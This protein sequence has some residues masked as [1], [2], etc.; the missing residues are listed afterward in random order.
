M[1]TTKSGRTVNLTEKAMNSVINSTAKGSRSNGGNVQTK[2]RGVKRN[3]SES[4]DNI[5]QS[6]R[7]EQLNL[8]ANEEV[9][10]CF[11]ELEEG[12]ENNKDEIKYINEN[13]NIVLKLLMSVLPL[14]SVH[15]IKDQIKDVESSDHQWAQNLIY[16]RLGGKENAEQGGNDIVNNT[17]GNS[18]ATAPQ[19]DTGINYATV[20]ATVPNVSNQ[21]DL[22]NLI[23]KNLDDMNRKKKYCYNRDGRRL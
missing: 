18:T 3:E 19:T 8:S 9:E 22:N 23:L 13:V 7:S 12:I 16:Q 2:Q 11:N 1:I 6:D 15:Q 21:K 17:M 14:T 20:A 5:S 10:N 4:E